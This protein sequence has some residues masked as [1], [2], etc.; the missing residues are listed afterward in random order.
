[1][2]AELAH[3]LHC[4]LLRRRVAARCCQQ[5]GARAGQLLPGLPLQQQHCR[6]VKILVDSVAMFSCLCWL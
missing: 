1:M 2:P 3:R 6:L 5:G 4:S